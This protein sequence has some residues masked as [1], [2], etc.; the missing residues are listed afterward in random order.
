MVKLITG[1]VIVITNRFVL[2]GNV[3]CQPFIWLQ[4]ADLVFVMWMIYYEGSTLP[5]MEAVARIVNCLLKIR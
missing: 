1:K 2:P 3:V 4:L 5:L